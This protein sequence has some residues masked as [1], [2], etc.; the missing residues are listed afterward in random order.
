MQAS[1]AD[2]VR[3]RHVHIVVSQ[4]QGFLGQ[5][6]FFGSCRQS[7]EL[8]RGLQRRL[9]HQGDRR[10]T[11]VLQF[12]ISIGH[13]EDDGLSCFPITVGGKA[14]QQEEEG[15][16][17][18]LHSFH[19]DTSAPHVL[20]WIVPGCPNFADSLGKGKAFLEA[21]RTVRIKPLAPTAVPRL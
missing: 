15:G 11:L 19:G 21:L 18:L 20:F 5:R 3:K 6:S 1:L 2:R 13:A 14:N 16:G 12:A 8:L 4:P 9:I 7:R 10:R 17:K